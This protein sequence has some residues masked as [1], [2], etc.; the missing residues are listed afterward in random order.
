MEGVMSKTPG[1]C[2]AYTLGLVVGEPCAGSGAK[3][4]GWLGEV[5]GLL[6]AQGRQAS[7][8]KGIVP[9]GLSLLMKA[10]GRF[11]C[12]NLRRE[13][14]GRVIEATTCLARS[15]LMKVLE[16]IG[17]SKVIAIVRTD[18][19]E[20]L[21]AA[22]EALSEGGLK[23]IEITLTTPG[24]LK[25]LPR[26][27]IRFPDLTLG[28]GTVI[29]EEDV[30]RSLEAGASFLVAPILDLK[31]LQLAQKN[32]ILLIPGCFTP[33][34]IQQ[35]W[36]AGAP[37]VKVFPVTN[38]EYIKAIRAPL[39]N[40]PLVPTGG[41]DLRNARHYLEAGAFAIGIGGT[42][43]NKNLIAQRDFREIRKRAE[44]LTQLVRQSI[45]SQT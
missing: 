17:Q 20:G 4:G 29:S 24:S 8:L 14:R 37:A 45:S 28:I 34:E 7:V 12:R 27:A 43:V 13:V 38:P 21:E 6:G 18:R 44:S 3:K 16:V 35:A 26:L 1:E 41:I 5:A 15:S 31:A 23:A 33:T 9:S 25:I 42:L 19:E 36:E 2:F 32:D 22:I 39:P 30:M 40:I 10:L 11:L